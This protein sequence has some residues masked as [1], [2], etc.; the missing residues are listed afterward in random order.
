M[1]PLSPVTVK[2]NVAT[3]VD[4]LVTIVTL[5]ICE[6][7]MFPLSAR[8]T[9]AP[10]SVVAATVIIDDTCEDGGTGDGIGVGVGFTVTETA[11]EAGETTGIE[12]LSVT[13][14]VTQC[15]APAAV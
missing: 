5:D 13:V 2:D 15:E 11:I 3:E 7:V 9:V 10:P 14:Q 6:L 4:W 1:A 8:S 12:A